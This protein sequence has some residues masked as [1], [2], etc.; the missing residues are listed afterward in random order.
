MNSEKIECSICL[1]E[2]LDNTSKVILQCNHKY[3]FNCFLKY[4]DS[5]DDYDSDEVESTDTSLDKYISCPYCRKDIKDIDPIK[6]EKELTLS[7]IDNDYMTDIEDDF[8]EFITSGYPQMF[9]NCG[10]TE[11]ITD[12]F[13]CL[14]ESNQYKIIFFNAFENR[15]I[16]ETHHY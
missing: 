12:N 16:M 4:I 7:T 3:H 6:F 14:N 10:V 1:E 5:I 11:I 13:I 15:Y 2:I 8:E 9:Y